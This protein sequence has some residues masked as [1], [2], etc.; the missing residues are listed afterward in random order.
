MGPLHGD[1]EYTA[2][3]TKEGYVLTAV[4]GKLGHFQAF[5]LGQ[6][7]VHVTDDAGEPLQGVLLSLSGETQYRSNKLSQQDG[8]MTFGNLVSD[9]MSRKSRGATAGVWLNMLKLDQNGWYF[10]VNISKCI[11][12]KGKCHIFLSEF[13]LKDCC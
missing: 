12:F 8:T 2:A 7:A 10:V 13:H 5:K 11:L 1:V 4:A 3:A 9:W 6:I